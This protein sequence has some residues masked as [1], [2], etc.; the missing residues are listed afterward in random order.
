ML[1]VPKDDNQDLVD[2]IFDKVSKVEGVKLLE[3]K[4]LS[5]EEP[6]KYESEL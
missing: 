2:G 6:R 5:Q 3:K 1:V 4:Y